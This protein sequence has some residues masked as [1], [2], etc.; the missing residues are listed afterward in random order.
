VL[1]CSH[2][3]VYLDGTGSTG[4]IS[5]RMTAYRIRYTQFFYFINTINTLPSQST[6]LSFNAFI[7]GCI[8]Q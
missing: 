7:S 8:I 1:K 5:Y 2:A 3:T 4:L 6:Y